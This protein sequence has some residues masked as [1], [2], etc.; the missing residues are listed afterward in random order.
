MQLRDQRQF[1][2]DRGAHFFRQALRI[3][4][5]GALVSEV[6]ER[7]LGV[8]EAVDALVGIFVAQFVEREG[9]LLGQAQRLLDRLRR[10]AEQPRHFLRRFKMALG[11]GGELAPGAVDGRLLADAG[12]H[13]GERAAAGVV[14]EHV[15]DRD[16]RDLCFARQRRE[17]REPCTV[18]PAIEHRRGQPHAARRCFAQARKQSR[19]A[20]HGDQLESE[21]MRQQVVEIE[22]AL[23]LFA[24]QVA[25]REQPREPA[26]AGAVARVGQNVRRA[27]GEDQPRARVIFQREVLLA[28]GEMRAHH[29][30][31]RIA[32]AEAEA[33]EAELRRLR[34]Q[35]FRVRRPAQEGEIRGAG[36][37]EVGQT[38]RGHF[39]TLSS[40]GRGSRPKAAG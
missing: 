1:V 26:P 25:E 20:A 37:F 9:E 16:Q 3:A 8:G 14:I 36:E 27:V 19:I 22:N 31:H 6:R 34:H 5:G 10:V 13:V 32:V 33:G 21:D 12:E 38:Q 15:V 4:P 2:L 24:A 28:S 18:A 35:L 17:T 30:G 7:L 23:A 29:A 39:L 40:G 11:I